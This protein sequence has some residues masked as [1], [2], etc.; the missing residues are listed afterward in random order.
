VDVVLTFLHRWVGRDLSQVVLF[1][2][3]AVF[4]VAA[5]QFCW[6]QCAN[7][8]WVR[9]RKVSGTSLAAVCIIIVS[10]VSVFLVGLAAPQVM[11]GDEVT[12]FYMLETQSHILPQPNFKAHIPTNWGTTEVRTYPHSFLWHYFG[13]ILYKLSG[14]SFALVQLYQALF[15]AQ[16]LGAAYLLASSR[17]GTKSKSV[18]AYLLVLATIP[19]TLMFS[20]TFYQDIPMAAQVVT[21]FYL[22]SKDHWLSASLFMAFAIG[23]KVTAILFFPAFFVCFIV[24]A[25]LRHGFLRAFVMLCCS[26]IIIGTSTWG[27]G[28]TINSYTGSEFYPVSKAHKLIKIVQEKIAFSLIKPSGSAHEQHPGNTVKRKRIAAE[29]DVAIIA[30]HP[31]DLRIK[32]NYFVFGGIVL[33]LMIPLGLLSFALQRSGLFGMHYG[34]GKTSTWWLWCVGLSYTVLVA[35]F[36]KTA[37]DARFFLPGLP[38][39]LLPVIEKIVCLPRYRWIISLI[40]VLAVLQG[41]YVLAK[42][43]R[44]RQVSPDLKR[45]ITYLEENSPVPAKIFMYPEGNYR[46]F[47]TPHEWYM[48]YHLRDFWRTDNDTRLVMLQKYKIGA[49]VIKKYLVAPVDADIMNLGVYPDYFVKA[50]RN[51]GRFRKVF[52][53]NAVL[54][55][56]VPEVEEK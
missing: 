3:G 36:L 29:Q 19:M 43:Y 8:S 53:N 44:L 46:L 25:V 15:L 49:I 18:P 16:F 45:A 28:K 31:G 39:L 51:D 37:P 54:I 30:N 32:Q 20:V 52:A 11:V 21:G 10:V 26:V 9:Q 38:F 5:A 33:W 27:L 23:I 47:P 35:F 4:L 34:G 13:A 41:G 12:H 42:T 56:A 7:I 22:L 14:G 24:W 17:G 48:N 2:I 40:A 55:Y 50:I 6:K 1:F